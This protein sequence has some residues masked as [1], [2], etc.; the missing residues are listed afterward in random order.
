MGNTARPHLKQQQKDVKV[1]FER[2]LVGGDGNIHG[3]GSTNN[4][5]LWDKD[6]LHYSEFSTEHLHFGLDFKYFHLCLQ[7]KG[8]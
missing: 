4:T 3:L 5:N 7:L 1:H 8:I 2:E 6:S